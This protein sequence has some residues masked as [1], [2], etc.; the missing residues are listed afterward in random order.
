LDGN[1]KDRGTP[2]D[3]AGT[4][5]GLLP[6]LGAGKTHKSA[7]DN[8]YDKPI[9]K[10][11]LYLIRKQDKRSGNLGGGMYSHGLATIALCE[12][13][14]LTQDPNLRRPAQMAVNYIIK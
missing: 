2:N 6:L 10:A 5:F 13:Y 12:A 1:F 11:L 4:A 3:T 9:E 14:G 8:P 7:P